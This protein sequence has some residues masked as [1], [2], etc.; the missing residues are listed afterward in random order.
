MKTC[1]VCGKGGEG[2]N[3]PHCGAELE[4]FDLN[5]SRKHFLAK[6]VVRDGEV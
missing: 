3:C 6:K 2:N 1:V 5:K 4:T